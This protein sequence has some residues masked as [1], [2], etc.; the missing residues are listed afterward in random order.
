MAGNSPIA[1]A[2]PAYDGIAA[3]HGA[4]PVRAPSGK[5]LRIFPLDLPIL[6]ELKGKRIILASASPRRRQLLGQVSLIQ[7]QSGDSVGD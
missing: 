1:G 7:E 2:S 5:G 4:L 3:Q 6:N